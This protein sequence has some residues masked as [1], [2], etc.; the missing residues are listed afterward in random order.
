MDSSRL[1][2]VIIPT[3]QMKKLI[4]VNNWPKS[5]KD[6]ADS[7]SS[8]AVLQMQYYAFALVLFGQNSPS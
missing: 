5:T 7:H 1:V 4:Q 3:L 8:T 2:K 6:R